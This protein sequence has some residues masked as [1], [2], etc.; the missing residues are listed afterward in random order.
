MG[1]NNF[2]IEFFFFGF[3]IKEGP[4]FQ[5]LFLNKIS[6]SYS[7]KFDIIQLKLKYFICKVCQ[8][9]YKYSTEWNYYNRQKL[10]DVEEKCHY[11]KSLDSWQLNESLLTSLSGYWP[12]CFD[13][14]NRW[15]HVL[16]V[17]L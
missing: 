15:K 1:W 2:L 17:D 7:F 8:A 4:Y 14:F 10:H 16:A 5:W 13:F 6:K 9:N 12:K 11:E 3:F